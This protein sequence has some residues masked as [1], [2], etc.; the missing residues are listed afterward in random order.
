MHTPNF[1]WIPIYRTSN[2]ECVAK[3]LSLKSTMFPSAHVDSHRGEPKKAF[4]DTLLLQRHTEHISM[5]NIDET[6]P[7]RREIYQ[8]RYG[9]FFSGFWTIFVQEDPSEGLEISS[10]RKLR[11]PK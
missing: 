11:N 9:T 6:R 7:F 10:R 5:S 2:S 8:E 1:I 4:H 3:S